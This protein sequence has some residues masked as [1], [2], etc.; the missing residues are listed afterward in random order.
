MTSVLPQQYNGHLLTCGDHLLVLLSFCLFILFMGFSKQEYWSG[1]PFPP[2]VDHA[3]PELFIM[4][5]PSWVAL[6]GM[7]HSFTELCEPLRHNKAAIHEGVLER[8]A[9]TKPRLCIKKQRYCFADKDLYNQ[10]Y[11]FSSSHIRIWQLDYKECWTLKNWSFRTVVLEKTLESP[12]DSKGIKPVNPKGNQS[13]IF[14]GRTD[15]EA[16]ILR[17]PDVKSWLIGKDPEAGKHWGQEEKGT[18]EDEMLD[19]II[20]LMDKLTWWSL[21]KLQDTVKDKEGWC[22]AVSGVAVRHDLRD[23]TTTKILIKIYQLSFHS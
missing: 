19:G 18:T 9:M 17:P 4:T 16:P 6:H 15:A 5:H 22:T 23:W 2:T 21:S 8:K 12:L 20:N 14:I 3:L 1:L 10:S 13:W 7:A 11:G